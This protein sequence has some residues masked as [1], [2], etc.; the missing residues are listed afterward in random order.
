VFSFPFL[1]IPDLA[2][3]SDSTKTNLRS[4][5]E[6]TH[7]VSAHFQYAPANMS[8]PIEPTCTENPWNG[9]SSLDKKDVCGYEK[10]SFA[11]FFI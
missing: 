9:S 3:I 2:S 4:V 7:P 10:P 1:F 11:L 6:S 5:V 8:M